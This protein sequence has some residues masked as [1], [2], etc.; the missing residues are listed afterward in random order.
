[1]PNLT[2]ITG[3]HKT[4]KTTRADEIVNTHHAT[5]VIDE[6]ENRIN[7]QP[8]LDRDMVI[9]LNVPEGTTVVHE[10]FV[11][12]TEPERE[13]RMTGWPGCDGWHPQTED[14]ARRILRAE[15]DRMQKFVEG[16]RSDG[17]HSMAREMERRIRNA[18]YESRVVTD[19]ETG[20]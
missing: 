1:M 12:W 18:G 5:I 2:I 17:Q 10:H 13:Y 3:N 4:G 14:D 15:V 11:P 7:M 19:W 6:A 20:Q 9:V 8:L 16:Y